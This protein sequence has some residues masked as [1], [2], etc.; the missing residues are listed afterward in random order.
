MRVKEYEF[1]FNVQLFGLLTL[2]FAYYNKLS[3]DQILQAAI[4]NTSGYTSQLI[5]VGESE[6]RGVEMLANFAPIRGDAFTWDVTLNGSYNTSEVLKLGLD[7]ADVSIGGTIRQV[8]GQPLGQI[9]ERGYLRDAQG[10]KIFNANNGLPLNTAEPIAL[11]SAIP[12]WV[13]GVTN[14]FHYKGFSASFLVDFKLGHD[15]ISSAEFDYVR[16]GK[17]KKS[18]IGREQGFVIGEGVTP[19]GS[20]NQVQVDV[21]TFYEADARIREDFVYNAG[22]WKLRQITLGYD[23]TRIPSIARLL[24]LQG[25]TLSAV[26]NNVYTIKR[27]TENMDPEQVHQ[28][29]GTQDIALP[30]VRSFGFNLRAQF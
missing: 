7:D 30:M 10:R 6:N 15:L 18:L 4:S 27:W 14:M 5:N 22:F 25:L 28:V 1:G 9:Y 12:K 24:S 13:G 23:F 8:V 16:H 2:D 19:D 21:Q 20:P 29:N 17:H 26:A 11:G 3:I